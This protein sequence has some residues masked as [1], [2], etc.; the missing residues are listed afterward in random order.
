MQIYH[1]PRCAKSRAALAYLENKRQEFEVIRYLDQGISMNELRE[2]M[3]KTG[4]KA[5]ELVRT[6]EKEFK[7]RYKG[8]DFTDEEWLGIIAANPKLMQRPIVIHGN[9]AVLAQPPEEMDKIFQG[10][11]FNDF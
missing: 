11:M 6:Q 2:I 10:S 1:N 3:F 4:K 8:R 5:L 9:K 7:A